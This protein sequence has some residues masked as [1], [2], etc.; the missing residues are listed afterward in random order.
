MLLGATVTVLFIDLVGS[1]ALLTELGEE[2][3]ELVLAEHDSLVATAITAHRGEWVKHTGDGAMAAFAAAVDG[4]GAAVEVQQAFERRNRRADVPLEV[5]AGLSAGDVSYKDGD[6]F[7]LA[8]VQASRLCA[9]AQGGQIL[10]ADVIRVLAGSRGG[11]RLVSIGDLELK[12]LPPLSAVEVIWEPLG[13][14]PPAGVPM[15]ARL[16][17]AAGAGAVGRDAERAQL[18]D[19]CKAT[20]ND[21]GRRL[22]LVVGEAGIGKTTIA[23]L[24]TRDAYDDGAIVVYGRCD[25][26][27]GQPCQ[28]FVE[29]LGHLVVHLPDAALTRHADVYGGELARLVPTLRSRVAHLPSPQATDPEAE[30]YLLFGA[31][32]GLVALAAESAPVVLVLDDLHWADHQT[33]LLLRHIASS[34][35]PMRLLVLAI[36]RDADLGSHQPLIQTLAALR[37]ERDVER[38]TLSGLSDLEVLEF[39]KAAG[40]GELDRA[41]I[42]V[43]HALRQETDGNPFF[44]V[45]L[46]RHLAE[47]GAIPQA[48]N[49][50]WAGAVDVLGAGL[51]DSIREVV[52]YRVARLGETAQRVLGIASVVGREIDLQ[53]LARLVAL[54]EDDVLDVLERASAAS[55]V[56]EVPE[57]PGRFSF[58]HALVQHTLYADLGPAR[59]QRLHRRVAELLESTVHEP[60][61]R[62][63]ELAHHW[64]AATRPTDVERAVHYTRL[65]GNQAL[66]AR[67]PDDGVRW[68][69]QSLE[70]LAHDLRPD[71]HL[72][73]ELL[74][75]LGEAQRQAGIPS[76]RETLLDAGNLAQRFGGTDQLV[77]AALANNRVR[78]FASIAGQVDTERIAV[79]QAALDALGEADGAARAR[80]LA[81]L[82][83]ELAYSGDLD[84]RRPLSAE[85]LSLARRVGDPV[86]LLHVLL[87]GQ[88]GIWDPQS[89]EERSATTVEAVELAERMGDPIARFW[90]AVQLSQQAMPL[91]DLA[92]VDRCF[93]RLMTLAEEVG[94][95]MLRWVATWQRTWWV[96]LS[97]DHAESERLAIEHLQLASNMGEP[98]ALAF[99]GA[100]FMAIRWHQGRIGELST[101][102]ADTVANN[103]GI[104]AFRAAQ[105]LAHIE[106]GQDEEARSLL[107]AAAELG[108]AEVPS[109]SSWLTTLAFY[110][111][112][113]ARLQATGPAAVLYERL[114]PWRALIAFNGSTV[115]GSVA[116][117]LGLLGTTL[118][119]YDGAES[120]FTEATLTHHRLSAPFHEAR[121]H[122]GWAGLCI[123]RNGSNDPAHARE[124]LHEALL[125]ARRFGYEGVEGRAG[126][127]LA[128]LQ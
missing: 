11:H 10:A 105:A 59:R 85:A 3:F 106:V 107:L 94:Q 86:T 36:Y 30:R 89:V 77:R 63:V 95:P 61:E 97:G 73:C 41:G 20:A 26:D 68:Y 24:A 34:S 47:T 44:V 74:L 18:S 93:A 102:I 16:A 54:P 122:V 101:L 112:V 51:P 17:A 6:Y 22:V 88:P 84:R 5:R 108:F 100:Q 49:D 43:G 127:M 19:A 66:A 111:E 117:Y 38:L 126:A 37:R 52:G 120:H 27:L 29:A 69:T 13:V 65:A 90:A 114:L 46:L 58:A 12:G 28:P 35:T 80:L 60:G 14:A 39:M 71:Q 15:P 109:D 128:S 9:A 116:Y 113:A 23:A 8:S 33:L 62:V 4:L 76:Y 25:E 64:V 40:G 96:L 103:P 119:R 118:G 87:Q 72:R 91:G 79:L 104:P 56:V 21:E 125:V 45:E 124:L 53:F 123:A 67:A 2:R 78:G 115:D 70:L 55:V 7:G 98:D 48:G 83:L 1:T 57:T 32:V 99:F 50:S 31:V 121:T 82:A 110:A 92:E 75:G 81:N 42:A